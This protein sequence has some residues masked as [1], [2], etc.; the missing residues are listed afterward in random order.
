MSVAAF[1][2]PKNLNFSSSQG[3]IS[4]TLSGRDVLQTDAAIN[5]GNSGG[6]LI[7]L[8][9]GKVIGVNKA[10]FSRKSGS[11]GLGFAVPIDLYVK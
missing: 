10:K 6:P 2:H 8:N 3:I 9:N 4:K 5:S 11:E 7:N 1:G